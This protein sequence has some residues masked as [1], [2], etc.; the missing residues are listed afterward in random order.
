[1]GRVVSKEN[2]EDGLGFLIKKK[3]N[4]VNV[5]KLNPKRIMITYV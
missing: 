4:Y 1:M 3:C 2:M 5:N